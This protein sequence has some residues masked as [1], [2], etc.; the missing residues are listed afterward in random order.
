VAVWVDLCGSMTMT[1][2]E[3]GPLPCSDWVGIRA[4]QS[5]F[6]YHS[7]QIGF[8]TPFSHSA[9]ADRRGGHSPPRSTQRAEQELRESALPACYGMLRAADPIRTADTHTRRNHVTVDSRC[10]GD[11]R[12]AT[13]PGYRQVAPH[14]NISRSVV[15]TAARLNRRQYYRCVRN[16]LR[17]AL[18]LMAE[19]DQ[20]VLTELT[21][22]GELPSPDYHPRM[23]SVHEANAAALRQI[24]DGHCWRGEHLVGAQAAEAAWLIA[25]HTVSDLAFMSSC[26][27]RLTI[28]VNAGDAP[29][30]QLAFLEDRVRSFTGL[31]QLYGT[32]FDVGEDGTVTPLPIENPDTVDDR[33][34]QLGLNTVAERAAEIR[35][36]HS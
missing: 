33:R 26:A 32:Q 29:G 14:S 27:K 28:A 3:D 8:T 13:S 12:A 16:D 22:A 15:S 10:P 5:D 25:Q 31:K 1:I 21:A 34:A 17:R 7:Q 2:V 19:H 9:N 24:I 36:R 23:R 35:S 18:I 6:K 30:W 11:A 20:Q 4:G